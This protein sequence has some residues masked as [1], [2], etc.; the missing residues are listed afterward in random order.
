M[1]ALFSS[2]ASVG[3]AAASV[4][5]AAPLPQHPPPVNGSS[6]SVG[7][8]G[9]GDSAVRR[10]SA[11]SSVNGVRQ[12][13]AVVARRASADTQSVASRNT[14]TAAATNT[15]A[16]TRDRDRDAPPANMNTRPQGKVIYMDKEQ[17]LQFAATKEQHSLRE[18]GGRK[19]KQMQ[20]RSAL[21]YE[22]RELAAFAASAIL[23]PREVED[24][25][26]S[27]PFFT[28]PPTLKL[29]YSTLLHYR[30]LEE[31]LSKTFKVIFVL[32]YSFILLV[33]CCISYFLFCL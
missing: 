18:I 8:G 33:L 4:P 24:L 20:S 12:Q 14:T 25:F 3:S 26:F 21:P 15:A 5:L 11:T 13:P 19:R 9:G 6:A 2:A 10:G 30:S 28:K 16:T 1:S 7:G 23:Q 17:L 27:L 22:I 31:L 32:C 29:L